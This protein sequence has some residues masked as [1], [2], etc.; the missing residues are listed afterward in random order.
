MSERNHT[1]AYALG[2]INAAYIAEA[3]IPALTAAAACPC[4]VRQEHHTPRFWESGWFAAAVSGIVAVGVM[5]AIILAGQRNPRP[6]V[7]TEDTRP[8]VTETQPTETEPP[9]ETVESPHTVPEG[10]VITDQ[11]Y[12]YQGETVILLRVRNE[13]EEHVSLNIRMTYLNEDGKV[14]GTDGQTVLGF[15][16]DHEKYLLFRVSGSVASYVYEVK[17]K[18]YEGAYLDHLYASEYSHIEEISLPIFPG[19]HGYIPEEFETD[20]TYYPCLAVRMT[21]AYTGSVPVDVT[22]TYVLFDNQGQ[23]Y[24]IP[25][26]GIKYLEAAHGEFLSVA[27][28]LHYTTEERVQ[29]PPELLGE[30]VTCIEIYSV[31]PPDPTLHVP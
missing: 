3:E 25:T 21:G 29:W 24:H 15:S 1:L 5:A 22:R 30:G 7:G 6:P 13:T 9:T 16:A 2:H 28:C 26:M 8:P 19:E 18:P 10:F 4:R 23:I 11:M 17:T 12:D 27:M 14:I 31:N 20:G